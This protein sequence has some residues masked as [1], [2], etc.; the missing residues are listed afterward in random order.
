MGLEIIAPGSLTTVQDLGRTGMMAL[1]FPPCGAMDAWSARVANALVANADG[2]AV[3]EMTLCGITARFTSPAVVAL[4]G[5]VLDADVNGVLAPHNT[6]FAVREG[7]ILTCGN[8]VAGCRAYL[9]VA[10]GFDV[11]AAFGS[12]STY[13]KG[14]MGGFMG[15]K[16]A[17]S[18]ILPFRATVATLPNMESRVYTPVKLKTINKKRKLYLMIVQK[19]TTL[20]LGKI[21]TRKI[22]AAR[23]A[24]QASK[25]HVG[26][27]TDTEA[28]S[29]A[30][31]VRVIPGPQDNYFTERGKSDFY[32]S[33]FIV[34][35]QSDRMGIRLDGKKIE[36]RGASE[37]ISDGMPLGAVQITPSGQPIVMTA[38]R[39]TV[40][41]YAKI[42]IVASV[43]VPLLA[44]ARPGRTMR[45]TP[46]S[47][48][49]ARRLWLN[50]ERTLKKL[51]NAWN[52][53]TI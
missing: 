25:P 22:S 9:A 39:Q 28:S 10:G 21:Y 29:E 30:I 14:K 40:G 26:V 16:L 42:A 44:Q 18:D 20:R 17:A 49:G 1:G 51:R 45:F 37:I 15:R 5:A 27:A 48:R 38:D 6:A 3:L 47:A 53:V 33:A 4:T 31:V 41:G 8:I 12:R 13:L 43:D 34:S 46:V 50:N 2:E 19:L 36:F 52:S 11:P 35:T 24:S 7:D 32:S 23:K